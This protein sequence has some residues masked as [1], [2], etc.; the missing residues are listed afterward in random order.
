MI[1]EKFDPHKIWSAALFDADQGFDYIKRFRFEPT[2]KPVSFIGD[3]TASELKLIAD[4]AYPLFRIIFGGKDKKREPID[5]DVEQFVGDKSY[6]ARG[7]RISNYEVAR[8]ERLE[9][10]RLP[11]E[12]LPDTTTDNDEGEYQD[13]DSVATPKLIYDK[14]DPTQ[15]N[16]FE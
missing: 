9:P 13:S 5:I 1:I 3:N 2:A 16:L 7:K 6:K 4:D 11:T 8:V 10:L 12:E 14:D 15:G